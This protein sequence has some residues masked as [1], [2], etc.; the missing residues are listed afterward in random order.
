MLL[1]ALPMALGQTVTMSVVD[2]GKEFVL[3]KNDSFSITLQNHGDGGYV[4]DEPVYN[5]SVVKLLSHKHIAP[6][7]TGLAG[8]FGDDEWRFVVIKAP[9]KS[10]VKI[11]YQR[12]WMKGKEKPTVDFAAK[13]RTYGP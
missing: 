7:N 8:D 5:K 1:L 12:P 6:E 4:F 11:T 3:K 2:N 9:A 10:D 13:I